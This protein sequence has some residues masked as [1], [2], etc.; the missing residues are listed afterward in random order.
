MRETYSTHI[1][2]LT[3]FL[4]LVVTAAFA[5]IQNPQLAALDGRSAPALPHSVEG[6]ERC[7]ACHGRDSA[8]PY[9]QRHLGWK[10]AHCLRCHDGMPLPKSSDETGGRSAAPAESA[11]VFNAA[12]VPHP[13]EGYESCLGCHHPDNGILRAPSSHGKWPEDGC[14]GCHAEGP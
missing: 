7:L 5:I 2:L 9:P 6:R 3:G 13:I 11:H 10:E 4:I 12:P 14:T 8:R 1:A